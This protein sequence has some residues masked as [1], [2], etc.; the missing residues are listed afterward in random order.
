VKGKVERPSDFDGVVYISLD[1]G[2][3][4]TELGKELEASGFEID[5]NAVMRV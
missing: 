3:W 4:K 1:Q 2:S 5:W